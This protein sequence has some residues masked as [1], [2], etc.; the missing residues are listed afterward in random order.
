MNREL[1]AKLK[2][3][4]E[5]YRIGG[6]KKKQITWEEYREIIQAAKDQV[7]KAKLLL[8]LN[9]ARDIKGN[10]KSFCRYNSDKRKTREIVGP[11]QKETGDLVTQDMKKAQSSP[12]R[13]S[14]T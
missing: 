5:A 4:R 6:S 7:R 12:A 3:K 13:V 11:L 9:L 1:L 14:D 2:P 10:K 8:Q